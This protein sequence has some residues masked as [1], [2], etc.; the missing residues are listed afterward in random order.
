[1]ANQ[2]ED[3]GQPPRTEHARPPSGLGRLLADLGAGQLISERTS[4]LRSDVRVPN[5]SPSDWSVPGCSRVVD[6][7]RPRTVGAHRTRRSAP[8]TRWRTRPGGPRGAG[9]YRR[10]G[11]RWWRRGGATGHLH[12]LTLAGTDLA[13][14]DDVSDDDAAWAP[15]NSRPAAKPV[16]ATMAKAPPGLRQAND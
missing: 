15:R 12:I 6:P 9:G 13:L 7:P 10:S 1:M 2:A 3:R 11:R 16:A 4:S 8:R 14:G 5:R